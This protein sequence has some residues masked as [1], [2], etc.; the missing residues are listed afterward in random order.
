M[1]SYHMNLGQC[2]SKSDLPVAIVELLPPAFNLRI[3]NVSRWRVLFDFE[4]LNLPN[5]GKELKPVL[6]SVPNL[7]PYPANC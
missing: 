5:S 4:Q 6:Q 1:Q 7:V 2:T 3:I